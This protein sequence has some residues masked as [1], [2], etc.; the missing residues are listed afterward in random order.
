MDVSRNIVLA[1]TERRMRALLALGVFLCLVAVAEL[2]PEGV[3]LLSCPMKDLTGHTCLT[4]GMTRSLQA[5]LRG[6]VMRSFQDH[7]MG[8]VLFSG[9]VIAIFLWSLEG[10]TGKRLWCASATA[11]LR[12]ITPIFV[13][14]WIGYCLIRWSAEIV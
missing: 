4:C 7:L 12:K 13:I 9:M 11:I 1:P 2:P 6:D 3:P 14:I 8:P 5:C 10:T